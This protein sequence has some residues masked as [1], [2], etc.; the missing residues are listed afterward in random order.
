MM[1]DL[2][3]VNVKVQDLDVT[4]EDSRVTISATVPNWSAWQAAYNTTMYTGGVIDVD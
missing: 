4:V 3:Y 1:K 2:P